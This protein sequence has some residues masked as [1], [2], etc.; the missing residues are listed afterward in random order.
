MGAPKVSVIIP[1]YQRRELVVRAV[2][3]VLAQTYRD[4]ELIV[5]DDGSTDGTGEAV[6]LADARLRYRW[7]PNRGVAAARN[8]GLE[9]GS[10]SIFAFLDSDARWLPDHLEVI[11]EV[12]ARHPPAVLA[13]TC[14]GFRIAGHGRPTESYLQDHRKDLAAAGGAGYVSCIAVRR[15]PMLA[16]G[17]FDE[18]L[19]AAEDTDLLRRLAIL[20]PFAEVACRTVVRQATSGGLRDR[21]Q[22]AG[23]YTRAAELSAAN[24]AETVALLPEPERSALADQTQALGHFARAIGALERGDDDLARS[25]LE[26]ACGGYP[27]SERPGLVWDHL[28]RLSGWDQR[29]ERLRTL[30]ALGELWPDPHATTARYIRLRAAGEALRAGRLKDGARLLRDWRLA[31]TPAFAARI[32]PTLRM[33][34]RRHL[35]EWRKRGVEVAD[36]RVDR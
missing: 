1:T 17:G 31:G 12:L 2:A 25:E 27:F 5:V 36:L 19:V 18:R 9:M 30:V 33:E 4:L 34:A 14:P 13:S 6:A 16:A 10:G 15:G 29:Q 11:T 21:A 35:N 22:R 28:R 32:A 8:V 24:L 3:S 7:Q 20:G 23:A 26:A